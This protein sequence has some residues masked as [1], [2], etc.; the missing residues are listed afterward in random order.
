[1]GKRL[2]KSTQAADIW[3]LGCI[4]SE[5]AVW[6]ADGYSGVVEYRGQRM[7]EIDKMP[8]FQGGDCFHD[9]ER[10]LKAVLDAHKDV[11]L[12]LRRSDYITKDVLD[13]MVEEMLWEEDRPGAK[14]LLRRAEGIL[15]RARQRLSSSS[16]ADAS[17]T[18][19]TSSNNSRARTYPLPQSPPR[20]PPERPLPERPRISTS[21]SNSIQRQSPAN[22]EMWR[23]LVR[24][25]SSELASSAYSGELKTSPESISELDMDVASS[26]SGWQGGNR[27]SLASPYTSPHT[28]PHVSSHFE[29]FSRQ[30]PGEGR[31]GPSPSQRSSSGHQRPGKR[32]HRQS[33]QDTVESSDDGLVG[34][35]SSQLYAEFLQESIAKSSI[36]TKGNNGNGPNI[37]YTKT[38]DRGSRSSSKAYTTSTTGP[39]VQDVFQSSMSLD[40]P[41][42]LHNSQQRSQGFSLFPTKTSSSQPLPSTVEAPVAKVPT[43]H[44]RPMTRSD[45]ISNG[46]VSTVPTN[47]YSAYQSAGHLSLA[48][49]LEWKKAHKKSKKNARVPPVRGAD[50]L[51]KL[52]NRD[53]VCLALTSL[54]A[55]A[56]YIYRYS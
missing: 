18:R 25:P 51:D 39:A 50:L 55:R 54:D 20:P 30:M 14:A 1:M 26:T 53:H 10:V 45:S 46:S 24:V 15:S 41:P 29:N 44:E 37:D 7:A 19:P 43:H 27:D 11:E 34:P 40:D 52:N 48:G 2:S 35:S 36:N 8:D 32:P 42:V 33:L 3:S 31:H 12:R 47:H 5:A 22:V 56:D 17:S 16:T 23:T 21:R 4:Y 9:G 13:S 6:I 49:V 28:S 38:S